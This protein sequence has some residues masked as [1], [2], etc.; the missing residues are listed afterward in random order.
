MSEPLKPTYVTL[1]SSGYWHVRFGPQQFVQWPKGTTPTVADAFG[2][3]AERLIEAAQRAV[4][5]RR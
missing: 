2:W 5:L 3:D 1:L 4:E